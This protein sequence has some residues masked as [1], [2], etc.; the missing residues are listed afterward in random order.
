MIEDRDLLVR[1][2]TAVFARLAALMLPPA[3]AEALVKVAHG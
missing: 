1:C 2:R 3:K